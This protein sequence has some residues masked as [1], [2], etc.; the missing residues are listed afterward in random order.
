M[1]RCNGANPG[2]CGNTLFPCWDGSDRIEPL[3]EI[4]HCGE[5]VKCHPRQNLTVLNEG[6][7]VTVSEKDE[8]CL[9]MKLK[10]DL[11][12]QCQGGED[13]DEDKCK[14]AYLDKGFFQR[15]ET[16]ICPYPFHEVTLP[17]GMVKKLKTHRAIRCNAN[18][19]CWGGED[20]KGCN[21]IEAIAQYVIRK[22]SL[23]SKKTMTRK[24]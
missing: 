5:R 8:V 2:Q 9:D 18:P 4:G 15:D 23:F 17:D 14:Q 7:L 1:H 3:P 21:V 20:E 22:F 6:E 13:E 10:C 24:K 19:E 12:P 16:F 11:H